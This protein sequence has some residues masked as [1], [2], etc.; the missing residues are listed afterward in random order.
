MKQ[1][2]C[3][4]TAVFCLTLVFSSICIADDV[5]D[6]ISEAME[7]YKSGN[8][9]EAVSSL[10][11]A[12]QLIS[13]KKAGA[14]EA[15]LPLAQT[16]WNREGVESQA[17]S[18]SMFGGGIGASAV[19]TKKTGQDEEYD[20]PRIQVKI[21]ADSPMLQGMMV[22][23]SNPMFMGS[24]GG[25]LERIKGQQAV[26]R[27][28]TQ[29]KSGEINITVA[30]RFLITIEGSHVAREDMLVYANAIDYRK[31]TSLP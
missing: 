25:K 18:S 4:R 21:A 30:Q 22:M 9:T 28:D 27:Y 8:Y 15:F 19:Y 5:T 10:N 16:G 14:L 11:Y 13:Q 29:N 6:S 23:M 2:G 7:L 1:S 26:V 12:T 20:F 24:D 31:L 3:L 17:V